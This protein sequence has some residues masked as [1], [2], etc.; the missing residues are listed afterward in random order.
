MQ[1]LTLRGNFVVVVSD[2]PY[3]GYFGV[4]RLPQQPREASGIK[5]RVF[6]AMH[7]H[8]A[9]AERLLPYRRAKLRQR[10]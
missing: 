5:Q 2:L 1:R 6:L 7:R 4:I 3:I 10:L 8:H 9:K